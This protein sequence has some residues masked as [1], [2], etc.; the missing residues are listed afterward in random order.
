MILIRQLRPKQLVKLV[1]QI[2]KHHKDFTS[3]VGLA[4]MTTI[5]HLV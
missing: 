3:G 5:I 1:A 2:G 4:F